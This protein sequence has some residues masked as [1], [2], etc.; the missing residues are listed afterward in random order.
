[1]Y[2]DHPA[3]EV[4]THSTIPPSPGH[5]QK[6]PETLTWLLYAMN[7]NNT[8]INQGRGQ[9]REFCVAAA[10]WG[11]EMEETVMGRGCGS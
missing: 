2:G 3:A 9:T 6:R 10:C 8:L 5:M 7:N 1:M 4:N 11:L